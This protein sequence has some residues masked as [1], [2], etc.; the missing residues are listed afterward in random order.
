MLPETEK[1][2]IKTVLVKWKYSE[3]ESANIIVVIGKYVSRNKIIESAI[4]IY[5]EVFEMDTFEE[6]EKKNIS[7]QE[8]EENSPVI[9]IDSN[10]N[11]TAKW[12]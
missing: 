6:D 1:L 7:I 3:E 5:K 9:F 4:K 2:V 12:E 8:I 10:S 11:L